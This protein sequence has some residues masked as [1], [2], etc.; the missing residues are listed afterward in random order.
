MVEVV[1]PKLILDVVRTNVG[2]VM[3]EVELIPFEVVAGIADVKVEVTLSA[4]NYF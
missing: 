1:E 2:R 3:K 4:F